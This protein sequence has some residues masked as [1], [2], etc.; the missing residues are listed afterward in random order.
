M[1]N[2][3][4]LINR[5]KDKELKIKMSYDD[6][7]LILYTGGTTGMP[8]GVVLTYNNLITNIEMVG[9]FMATALP[10]VS[11]LGNR[12]Y[13]KRSVDKKIQ[14]AMKILSGLG[15]FQAISEDERLLKKISVIEL[16]SDKKLKIPQTISASQE[17]A[18]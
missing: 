7:G 5:N 18:S 14:N 13:E 15:V 17:A 1:V 16:L 8:K 3:Y 6:V 9:V 12:D 10:P 4:R 2:Y 11:K